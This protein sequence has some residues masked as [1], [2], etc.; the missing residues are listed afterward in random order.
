[1]MFHFFSL[2]FYQLQQEQEQQQHHRHRCRCRH[3]S[4]LVSKKILKI[5]EDTFSLNTHKKKKKGKTSDFSY[6]DKN[7]ITNTTKIL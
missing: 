4:L 1:M 7:F 6:F 2:V 5:K 3:P